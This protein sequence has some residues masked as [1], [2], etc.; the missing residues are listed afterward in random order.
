M[1]LREDT[2]VTLVPVRPFCSVPVTVA[3]TGTFG[4]VLAPGAIT[5]S[6]STWKA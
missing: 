3:V 2:S 5:T 4:A 6:A 1:K